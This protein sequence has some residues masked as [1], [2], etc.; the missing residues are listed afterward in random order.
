VLAALEQV[1]DT[2]VPG[3]A[4]DHR[5]LAPA[6]DRRGHARGHQHL[7]AMAV[8]GIEGLEFAAVLEEVQAA[9]GKHAIDVEH[10]QLDRLAAL[11][12]VLVHRVAPHHI[13]PARSKSC[14]FRAP[15]GRSSWSTTTSALILWSS[16]IFRASAAS[17]S[18]R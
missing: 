17:I 9:I 11:H 5:G 15:T 3:P 6:D 1:R 10:R 12:Q 13:T 16:M 8:E 14:M 7:D 4:F 18:A 2:Q